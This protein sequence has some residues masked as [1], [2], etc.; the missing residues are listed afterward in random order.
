MIRSQAP[1]VLVRS[2]LNQYQNQ[3][4]LA[5]RLDPL[6]RA[7]VSPEAEL[8]VRY[9][10]ELHR[11][12]SQKASQGTLDRNLCIRLA[13][14]DNVVVGGFLVVSGELMGLWG[15]G[16]GDFLIRDAISLGANRLD[17]F[18]GYLPRLY[19]KHGFQAILRSPNYT[20]GQPDVVWMRRP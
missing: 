6:V 10:Q 14:R 16:I 11:L 17:C 8:V 2:D 13:K 19:S 20:K 12:R 9:A 18:D 4:N 5:R 1:A 7:N 3:L 15:R